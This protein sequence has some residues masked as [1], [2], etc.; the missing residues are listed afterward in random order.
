[1]LEPDAWAPDW[2]RPRVLVEDPDGAVRVA[3]Q[4]ILERAGFEVSTCAGPDPGRTCPEVTR[5]GCPALDTA[6]VVY[7]SLDWH[8][9]EHREVLRAQRRRH[10][11][12][13]V[14]V[15]ISRP[16]AERL[17]DLLE[18]CDV[19]HVPADGATTVA[20]VRR[21]LSRDG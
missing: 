17:P 12:V 18:G 21:A 1:V 15:E 13:P 10:P 4:R 2:S 8:R 11:E 7:A 6:D 20:A 14:V 9:E 5:D 3:A 16:D 19:V